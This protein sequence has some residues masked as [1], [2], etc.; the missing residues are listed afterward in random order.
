[1][2]PEGLVR[3]LLDQIRAHDSTISAWV[4]VWVEEA[5]AAAR[6]AGRELASGH[7]RGP[8]HGIPIGIKD[9]ID[10]AGKAT[11]AGAPEFLDDSPQ[12]A[13]AAIISRLRTAGAILLGKTHTHPFAMGTITPQTHNPWDVE[14]IPGGSSGG[15]AAALAAGMVPAA[16]G[17]D[18]G[19]S[20]RLPAAL[21]G[22]TGIKPTN[23]RVS[24]QGVWPLAWTLD[25]LGPLAR[26]AE[27]CALL[28]QVLA[29]YDPDDARSVDIS[30]PNFSAGFERGVR[31]L[32]IGIPKH[33]FDTA[34]D[35]EI[36]RAVELA[37][38]TLEQAG[39]QLSD[40]TLRYAAEA[41][42]LIGIILPAEA[43]AFHLQ[44][45][46]EHPELFHPT[47]GPRLE[48]GL[49][50]PATAYVDAQRLRSAMT[51]AI[52]VLFHGVDLLLLPTTRE[53]APRIRDGLGVDTD[54]TCPFNLT[55]SPALAV[56]CGISSGGLPIGC[57][58]VSAHW[59]E[60]VALAAGHAYQQLTDW[61][62]KRPALR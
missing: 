19:G 9:L 34:I 18:T 28:L 46:T 16:L 53:V 13:D 22:V 6:L 39:A 10:V 61:H 42:T 44:R 1:L 32:R 23:G 17:S 40:V 57:Q 50:L 60:D 38:T 45:L 14:R 51:A 35:P 2:T 29:G 31:G 27:D 3:S 26:S 24:R 56:P 43:A 49:L 11:R 36:A 8:L 30:V 58:L 7:D 59:R 5:L 52:R 55:G 54:L 15:S 48:R 47:V 4:S 20:I 41:P 62:T 25:H 21:C 37:A 33:A 12:D